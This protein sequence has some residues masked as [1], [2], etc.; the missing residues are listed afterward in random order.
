VACNFGQDTA[1]AVYLLTE[2]HLRILVTTRDT[3][4]EFSIPVDG[5]LLQR[6]IGYFLD[7]IGHRR[8]VTKLSESKLTLDTI[9]DFDFREIDLVTLSACE[10]GMGGSR[11]DDGAEI[12]D[13]SALVQ[14]RGAGRVIASLWQVED[15]STSQLMRTLYKSF[16]ATRGDA[17]LGLQQAQLAVRSLSGHNGVSYE[18][19]YYWAG[20]FVSGNHP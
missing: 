9:S 16:S 8:D 18:P 11:T 7:G 10:T 5:A 13:L 2:H 15:A 3:Q 17:A 12:E 20:F 14:R 1:F 4:E 6:D 19:P